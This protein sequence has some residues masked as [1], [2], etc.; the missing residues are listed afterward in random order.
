MDIVF[1]FFAFDCLDYFVFACT[2]IYINICIYIYK[3]VLTFF[4]DSVFGS[5]ENK[6]FIYAYIYI[7]IV[8]F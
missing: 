7:H 3:M 6:Y 2:Y 4:G 5:R 8:W 1:G